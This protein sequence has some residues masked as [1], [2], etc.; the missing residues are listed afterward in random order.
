MSKFTKLGIALVFLLTNYNLIGQN[1]IW[2]LPP[3][4]FEGSN[5]GISSLPSG[6]G[7]AMYAGQ[8]ADNMHSS[9]S[10]QNGNLVLF[11][12]DHEVYDR[13]GYLVDDM[14]INYESKKGHNERII[15][16]MGNDCSKY[17]I[18]YPASPTSNEAYSSKL[19]GR[20]LYM[21]VYDLDAVNTSNPMATG[22]LE[23]YNPNSYATITD[24]SRRDALLYGY[25]AGGTYNI[26][27]Y[28]STGQQFYRSNIQITAT[29]LIDNC[30]YYV[31]VFDG[32]HII[33]YKLTSD[34]LEYDNYVFKLDLAAFGSAL[35]S[36]ME[37][38]KL[39]N[40]NYRIA[41]PVMFGGSGEHVGFVITEIDASTGDVITNSVQV[42]SLEDNGNDAYPH[43]A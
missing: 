27:Q 8:P 4:Q 14:R 5:F 21:A 37:L 32:M 29:D 30:F 6:G 15:L 2:T 35:R 19:Y 3:S 41:T 43:G 36:E 38:I 24:I 13:H 22:A 9:Y 28:T 1:P 42:V 11:T 16:P 7:G 40:G 12:V 17:A 31:Y 34:G 18:I 23:V 39:S 10:D 25:P 26:Y 20:R 33:R